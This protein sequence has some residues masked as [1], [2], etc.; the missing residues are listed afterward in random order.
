MK[1][2]KDLSLAGYTEVMRASKEYRK[3][4]GRVQKD[5]SVALGL[6]IAGISKRE[7]GENKMTVTEFVEHM[8]EVGMVVIC[9]VSPPD[10][11]PG[12]FLAEVQ[13]LLSSENPNHVETVKDL[14]ALIRIRRERDSPALDNV[15][16]INRD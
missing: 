7:R 1:D 12:Q 9:A 13:W 11:A 16:P 3:R 2:Y 15:V 4:S 6:T 10:S 5:L 8:E 14:C